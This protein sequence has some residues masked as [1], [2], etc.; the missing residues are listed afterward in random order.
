MSPE[1]IYTVGISVAIIM[2]LV[3]S[4]VLDKQKPTTAK[5]FIAKLVAR[6]LFF[7]ALIAIFMGFLYVAFGV[8][9]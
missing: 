6:A 2:A 1:L 5:E 7:I 9:R 8:F 3:W 4:F